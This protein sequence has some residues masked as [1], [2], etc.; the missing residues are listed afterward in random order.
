MPGKPF[1]LRAQICTC[2]ET[3]ERPFPDEIP[4]ISLVKAN[5]QDVA[6]VC[7]KDVSTVSRAL[8]N[9]SRISKKTTEAVQAAA[10]KLGYQPNLAARM[11]K[12]GHSRIFWA[13]VP[14]LGTIVDQRIA[15]R[16]SLTAAGR[17]F[18]TAITVHHGRQE[19]FERLVAMI[20]S[21]LGAG[22]LI[23]RRDIADIS[24]V[25]QLIGRGF[26]V[27]FVDVPVRR[28]EIGVVTTDN[29]R[30]ASQ[31]ARKVADEGVDCLVF[32]F[33]RDRNR[34]EE[35]RF[36]GAIE[37][38]LASGK[39]Y[40]FAHRGNEWQAAVRHQERLGLIC[41]G[42][43]ELFDL[44]GENAD[45]FSGKTLF[46]GCFDVWNG[47][48]A[49]FEE[50]WVAEQDYEKIADQALEH[51][52]SLA[53]GGDPVPSQSLPLAALRRVGAGNGKG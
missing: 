6:K 4:T 18:D 43:D 49:P 39:P 11:L 33:R 7:G 38:A 34:V 10:R 19:E 50:V 15:D 17:D 35:R 27:V 37:G 21:G 53:G 31:L 3:P 44:L 12:M 51:L 28:L 24:A 25:N 47:G 1:G 23:N 22:V 41:S 14:T 26:P 13:L 46:G 42:Q 29:H 40:V 36:D 52:L 5:L 2:N 48:R 9:D 20:S 16:I 8:K 30:A 32:G 45:L